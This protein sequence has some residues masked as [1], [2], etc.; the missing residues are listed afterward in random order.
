MT[1]MKQEANKCSAI[2]LKHAG[3][4]VN[5]LWHTKLTFS[6]L[7][8]VM[9]ISSLVGTALFLRLHYLELGLQK[10]LLSLVNFLADGGANLL[11]L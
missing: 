10:P 8:N 9:F 3:M 7:D 6:K 2:G 5:A 1:T 4:V 11:V